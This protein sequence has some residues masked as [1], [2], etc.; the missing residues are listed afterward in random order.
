M[1]SIQIYLNSKSAD[2]FIDSKISNAQYILPNINVH[3]GHQIYLSLQKASIPYSFYNINYSNNSLTIFY[4]S[5]V[6]VILIPEG[7]YNINTLL[8]ELKSALPNFIVTYNAITNKIRFEYTSTFVFYASSTILNVLGFD[9]NT[10]YTSNGSVLISPNCCNLM[11]VK[12]INVVTNLTT[13]N[14]NKAFSNVQSILASIP[15][16]NQPYSMIQYQNNNNFRSNLYTNNLSSLNIQ[17]VNDSDG[18]LIDLNGVHYSM[19]LQL[20]IINFRE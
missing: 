17:L 4:N 15:V 7:N 20:D 6:Y 14:V 13:Y 5:Q 18:S 8:T 19:T 3:D 11:S 16:D 10:Q 1:E 12:C 9:D 2:K